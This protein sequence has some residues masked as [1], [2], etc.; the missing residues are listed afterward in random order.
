MSSNLQNQN[1]YQAPAT[2][3]LVQR[4]APRI[5]HPQTLL[6]LAGLATLFSITPIVVTSLYAAAA[7]NL[8]WPPISFNAE[9]Y[10]ARTFILSGTL[11]IS[12]SCFTFIKSLQRR[13]HSDYRSIVYIAPA[14]MLAGALHIWLGA[15]VLPYWN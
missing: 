3:V 1:P 13:D 9:F 2:P 7:A 10:L 11:G 4:K 12:I 14:T 5:S 6:G 15:Y 8:G